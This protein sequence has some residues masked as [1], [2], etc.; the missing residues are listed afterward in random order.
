M[1]RMVEGDQEV[2]V[3]FE[4]TGE[5]ETDIAYVELDITE[6]KP[7]GQKVSVK[8]TD[9]LSEVSAEKSITFSVDF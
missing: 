5:D 9:L 3:S 2:K 8:V 7:G 4:Q 6:S 1:L